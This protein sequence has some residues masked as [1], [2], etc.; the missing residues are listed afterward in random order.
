MMNTVFITL[1][2]LLYMTGFIILWGWI[3][4]GSRRYDQ[5]LGVILPGWMGILGAVLMM[6][7]GVFVLACA[8]VFAVYGRGTPALFDPPREFVAFGP[9]KYTRNPMYIGGVTILVGFSL[10]H[11]S[12]SMVL[13]SLLLFLLFHLFVVFIEEPGLERRFGQSYRAYKETT[14]RWIPRLK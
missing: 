5:S 3:A 12:V 8:G 13:F 14:N 11:R 6:T 4:L 2:A 10:Y 9:Y 7:G 1:R